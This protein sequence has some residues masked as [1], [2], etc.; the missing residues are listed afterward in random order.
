ML[1]CHADL[2]PGPSPSQPPPPSDKNTVA[3]DDCGKTFSSK[4]V[5]TAHAKRE[6]QS[7]KDFKC[8][9]CLCL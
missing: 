8:S 2:T 4:Y 6:H 5:M 1:A 7:K 3:C 9:A